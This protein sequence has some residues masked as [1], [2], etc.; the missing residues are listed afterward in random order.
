MSPPGRPKG[1]YRSAQR[2]GTPM[3]EEIPFVDLK[4]QYAALKSGIDARIQ[5]VLDHGRYIMGP[6]VGELED[7]LAAYT[8]ARHCITVASGTLNSCASAS[9]IAERK[10][11]ASAFS[12][13]LRACPNA[14]ARSRPVAAK[15]ANG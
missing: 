2:E 3:S 11:S 12:A 1:E 5:R 8:G 15:A 7:K 6:E 4:S 13:S 10:T 14:A 9:R